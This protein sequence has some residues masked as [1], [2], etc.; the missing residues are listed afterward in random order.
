MKKNYLMLLAL[1]VVSL[2]SLLASEVKISIGIR[3]TGNANNLP[4]FGNGGSTGGIEFVNRDGQTLFLNNTWQLFTFTPTTDPLLAFAGASANSVLDTDWVVL[5]MIR[6]LNSGGNTAPLRLWIDNISNMT[7]AGT[8][9]EGFESFAL[10]SEVIFQ[11]PRFSGSTASQLDLLPNASL[12]SDSAAFAGTQ[13]DEINLKYIDGNVNNWVRLTTF[14][15]PNLPNPLLRAREVGAPAPTISFYM[16]G[17]LVPEPSS[18]T[19]GLL[20][21]G[22]W[23]GCRR[24]RT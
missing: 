20:G 3:E 10:N 24:K 11:E 23:F 5:E 4:I 15:T 14:S 12:V 6:I 18:V 9:T 2:N 19:I 7:S 17:I 1:G 16:K 21:L 22:A 8:V 13:S